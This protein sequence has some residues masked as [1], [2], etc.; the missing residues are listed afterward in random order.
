MESADL[1]YL[2]ALQLQFQE[3]DL[4][5][6]DDDS[7]DD[8]DYPIHNIT[9]IFQNGTLVG[10][11]LLPGVIFG[12]NN[13]LNNNLNNHNINYINNNDEYSDDED[14]EDIPMQDIPVTITNE[15][16]NKSIKRTTYN[17][18]KK[19]IKELAETDTC[20]I[21]LDEFFD[22]DLKKNPK[23]RKRKYA[24]TPCNHVFHYSC[25]KTYLQDYSYKCPLCR[26][27]CGKSTPKLA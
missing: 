13:N 17:Q 9:Q 8:V 24:I 3:D 25:L 1:D 23:D 2:Y 12:I 19:K 18:V 16:M 27:A 14:E 4:D 22:D 11:Q 6:S 7:D 10:I 20:S 5:D 26:E 21:C 15:D